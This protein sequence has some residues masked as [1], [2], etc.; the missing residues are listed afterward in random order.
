MFKIALQV[1]K[2]ASCNVGVRGCER[3]ISLVGDI[4]IK[5]LN[6]FF[7]SWLPN[8][9]CI[10]IKTFECSHNQV[11]SG[12]LCSLILSYVNDK[13]CNSDKLNTNIPLLQTS[14]RHTPWY[15]LDQPEHFVVLQQNRL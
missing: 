7:L 3:V 14:S 15:G 13:K 9:K 6:I 8:E 12:I 4:R 5:A 10:K 11:A 2:I 1:T